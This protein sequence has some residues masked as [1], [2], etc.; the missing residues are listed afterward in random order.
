[1]GIY[2]LVWDDFCSWF[3]KPINWL[4]NNRLIKPLSIKL[5][6]M[7]ENVLKLLHPFMPF[8]ENLA[9]YPQNV[10]QKKR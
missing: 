10:R 4:I 2:K 8:S 7:L 6:E 3:L 1:M 5:F 9:A